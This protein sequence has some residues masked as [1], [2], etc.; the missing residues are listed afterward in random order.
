MLVGRKYMI[1]E[2]GVRKTHRIGEDVEQILCNNTEQLR[3]II[4]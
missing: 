1:Q 4:R 3:C 2:S